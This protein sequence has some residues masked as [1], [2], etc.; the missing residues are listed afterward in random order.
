MTHAKAGDRGIVEMVGMG[1]AM[2]IIETFTKYHPCHKEKGNCSER[3]PPSPKI[4]QCHLVKV[5][6]ADIKMKQEGDKQHEMMIEK[7]SIGVSAGYATEACQKDEE[8]HK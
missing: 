2:Y 7:F 6:G 1:I 5:V 4:V 8:K 3:H